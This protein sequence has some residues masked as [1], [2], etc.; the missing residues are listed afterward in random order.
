MFG[1]SHEILRSHALW[2]VGHDSRIYNNRKNDNF[3]AQNLFFRSTA[4]AYVLI[5]VF[6]IPTIKTSLIFLKELS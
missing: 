6:K 1:R 2:Y 4:Y 3:N 5:D